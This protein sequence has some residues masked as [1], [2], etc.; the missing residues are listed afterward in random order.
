MWWNDEMWCDV[1]WY[2]MVW[3]NVTWCDAMWYDM[4][5][6]DMMI[7]YYVMWCGVIWWH[8]MMRCDMAWYD[9][10]QRAIRQ[11]RYA[12]M[13]GWNTCLHLVA[14]FVARETIFSLLPPLDGASASVWKLSHGIGDP[15]LRSFWKTRVLRF[16]CFC[17]T[18]K[19]IVIT[20]SVFRNVLQL[21]LISYSSIILPGNLLIV[22]R[23]TSHF[24]FDFF[25][26]KNRHI[27]EAYYRSFFC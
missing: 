20:N 9:W 6:Y 8:G 5:W 15:R 1:L 17:S 21:F 16:T 13:T 10:Q 25:R 26:D 7:Y 14:Y 27:L 4:L 2:D 12:P 3:C 22:W 24:I 19:K 18:G 23:Q 11:G